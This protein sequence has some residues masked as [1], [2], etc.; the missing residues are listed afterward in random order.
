MNKNDRAALIG[1]LLGDGSLRLHSYIKK[2]GKESQYVEMQIT[3]CERQRE[4]LEHKAKRLTNILGG[5]HVKVKE[6]N[7][8]TKFSSGKIYKVH[9]CDSYFRQVHRWLYSRDRKKYFTRKVLDFLT[10]E[11][12]AYWYMDDGGLSKT[13]NKRWSCEMRISTYFSEQEADVFIQYFHDV[14]GIT[15]KKRL[16]KKH[17]TYYMCFNTKESVKFEALISPYILPM[18]NYKLPSSWIPRTP[19]PENSG[20]DIC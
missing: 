1:M 5:K 4:Y 7:S 18:F 8:K 3:H 17:G 10:P 6:Y 14:W 16:S 11:G 20:D 12:I 9:K 19:A 2:D 15:A 13:K